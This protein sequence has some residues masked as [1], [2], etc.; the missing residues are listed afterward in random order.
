MSAA[1][2]GSI[3]PKSGRIL[4]DADGKV[5]GVE[6]P[7]DDEP[8]KEAVETPWG[9][10]MPGEDREPAPVCAKTRVARGK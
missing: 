3:P 8:N 9:A 7:E 10:P 1:A 4:R 5:I 2:T 6:I